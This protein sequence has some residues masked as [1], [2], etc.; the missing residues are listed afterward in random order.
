M[1]LAEIYSCNTALSQS[2]IQN[3]LMTGTVDG[4]DATWGRTTYLKPI[5]SDAVG[6]DQV[7]AQN[8]NPL[9]LQSDYFDFT[10]RFATDSP[11]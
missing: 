1:R 10:G 9:T 3:I 8:A 7:S 6:P 11:I 5:D 4:N 2:D